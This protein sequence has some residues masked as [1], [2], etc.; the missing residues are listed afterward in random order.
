MDIIKKEGTSE[1]HF[2]TNDKL[3][4]F[5]KEVQ[6]IF[7]NQL[8]ETHVLREGRYYESILEIQYSIRQHIIQNQHRIDFNN[9]SFRLIDGD[10]KSMPS[11]FGLYMMVV[12]DVDHIDSILDVMEQVEKNYF[13]HM[14]VKHY[15]GTDASAVL[16]YETEIHEKKVCCCSHKCSLEHMGVIKNYRT[17][18]HVVIGC[19]CIKKN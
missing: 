19:D 17:N 16:F 18:Y 3:K 15:I 4:I 7:K 5:M 11:L 10:P 12:S 13:V 6:T 2:I 14:G 8:E 1:V 9:K